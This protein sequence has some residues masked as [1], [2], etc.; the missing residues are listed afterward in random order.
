MKRISIGA[1]MKRYPECTHVDKLPLQ[2]ID[3]V[4][5]I[6]KLEDWK[7][8]K[9]NEYD[10]LIAEDVIEH[11]FKVV[12]VMDE[13]WRILKIGGK[14]RIRTSYW[15]TANS[16][17][18]PTHYHFFTEHSFDYW[19]ASTEIGKKYGWYCK[20][21]FKILRRQIDGQELV[22]ELEKLPGDTVGTIGLA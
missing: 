19:D 16:F 9:D 17:C 3:V 14:M 2:G 20:G 15:K 10:E 21:R 4:M 12:E 1:G 7:Q 8:F 22:F 6:D 11:S 18:D 13:C 5:D